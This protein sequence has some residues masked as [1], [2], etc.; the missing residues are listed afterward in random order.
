M[1]RRQTTQ[2]QW[3]IVNSPADAT[4]WVAVRHLPFGSGILVLR[5]LRADEQRRLRNIAALR[6]LTIVE[7]AREAARV[8]NLRELTKASLRSS[9]L[10]LISPIHP[11]SS[12]PDWKPLPRMRAAALA[13]LA[14]RRAIALGGMDERRYA[15]VARLGF[16][17]WAGISAFRI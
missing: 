2:S 7:S 13:R 5:P 12:H 1:K 6:G 17:G 8:H 14:N 15:K 9:R 11:T 4:L 10:I 16:S 3:L